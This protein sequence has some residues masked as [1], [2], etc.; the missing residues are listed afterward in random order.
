MRAFAMPHGPWQNHRT[1]IVDFLVCC[2]VLL[3][4]HVIGRYLI[5][6]GSLQIFAGTHLELAVRQ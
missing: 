6:K 4:R 5:H 2:L 3:L 1:I